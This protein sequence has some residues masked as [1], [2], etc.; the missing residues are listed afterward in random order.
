M[1][2]FHQPVK[3]AGSIEQRKLGVQMQM[4]K[5]RVR[6]D[7]N[8]AFYREDTKW[9]SFKILFRRLDGIN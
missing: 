7:I 5:V 9:Q 3:A 8:L 4:N 6:H 2:L 1:C